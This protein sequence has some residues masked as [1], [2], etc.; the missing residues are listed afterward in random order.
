MISR[1]IS[2]KQ[3]APLWGANFEKKQLAPLC[4]ANF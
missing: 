1:Y 3:L 2:K 4:G